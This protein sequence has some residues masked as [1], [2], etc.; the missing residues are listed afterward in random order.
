[1][2]LQMRINSRLVVPIAI[3]EIIIIIIT[4]IFYNKVVDTT[5]LNSYHS[6]A[7]KKIISID[8]IIHSLTLIILIM[9][10]VILVLM[11]AKLTL[12]T[13]KI[14]KVANKRL[15]FM[16]FRILFK[17]YKPCLKYFKLNALSNMYIF[18]NKFY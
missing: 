15:I 9:Y 16:V 13:N 17:I 4:K 6:M 12:M 3:L 8:L 2:K 7:E 10:L 5:I 11:T 1:M 14:K 18:F